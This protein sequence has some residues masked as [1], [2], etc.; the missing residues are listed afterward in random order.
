[1][2]EFRDKTLKGLF[3][4]GGALYLHHMLFN[5][6][7]FVWSMF[8]QTEDIRKRSHASNMIFQNCR[9]NGMA[10]VGCAILE[11]I[12]V[13]SLATNDLFILWGP[14]FRHVTL[15]GNIGR[16]KINRWVSTKVYGKDELQAPFDVHR[17][18]FYRETDWA[19]DI[20]E[21]RF[22][23]FDYDGYIP[24]HLIRRDPETQILLRRETMLK[25]DWRKETAHI[26]DSE[27]RAVLGSVA[28]WC[29]PD[30][31]E[32]VFAAPLGAS[33]KKRDE[34]LQYIKDLRAAGIAEQD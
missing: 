24:A 22:K 13:D 9:I 33:K 5:N 2:R 23:L 6:C 29:D 18:Q 30:R 16:V 11:D 8:S 3:D 20:S 4:S 14:V 15:M 17:E 28:E 19:L 1:M 34:V 12:I 10:D 7:E 21:A 31:A 32:R 26:I 25:T 27:L